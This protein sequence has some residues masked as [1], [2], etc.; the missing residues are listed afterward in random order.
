MGVVTYKGTG[1]VSWTQYTLFCMFRNN[2][3]EQKALF[4]FCQILNL[5]YNS[6]NA[7]VRI[8]SLRHNR[9]KEC[10]CGSRKN[11]V[12]KD[13]VWVLTDFI[14]ALLFSK[15]VVEQERCKQFLSLS[16]LLSISEITLWH[17]NL[18]LFLIFYVF[19]LLGSNF[20]NQL[21]KEIL[22]PLES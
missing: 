7:E 1:N 10:C 18:A 5:V 4:W 12:G 14:L 17:C 22:L 3:V 6:S 19:I 13:A 15:A 21:L 11:S 8:W 16:S 2:L 9:L 20:T